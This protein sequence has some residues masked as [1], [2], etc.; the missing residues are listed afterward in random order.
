MEQIAELAICIFISITDLKSFILILLTRKFYRPGFNS[1]P[2]K[3]TL[4]LQTASK[5]T[6][7]FWVGGKHGIT[8]PMKR[9]HTL[10]DHL[11]VLHVYKD[12]HAGF[13]GG[14][15]DSLESACPCR[16]QVRSL[17]REDPTFHGTT[18]PITTA[19]VLQSPGTAA[20]ELTRLE[21]WAQQEKPSLERSP[22]RCTQR[23]ACAQQGR[24]STARDTQNSKSVPASSNVT[25]RSQQTP[26]IRNK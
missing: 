21:P 23:K 7:I 17:A 5:G 13:S 11:Y 2:D 18:K 1:G 4:S 9:F 8:L 10:W 25:H 15:V 14:S 16:R 24:P 6:L 26:E 3:G 12:A 20:T 19:P 22:T